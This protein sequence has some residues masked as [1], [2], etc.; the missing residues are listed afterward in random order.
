MLGYRK[1]T[2]TQIYAKVLEKKCAIAK[3]KIGKVLKIV[4]FLK[5]VCYWDD[6]RTIE[7]LQHGRSSAIISIGM[8]S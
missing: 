8:L 2:A 7:E 4:P 6:F 1:P 5:Q 3:R